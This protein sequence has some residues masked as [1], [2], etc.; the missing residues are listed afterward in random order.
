MP[1]EVTNVFIAGVG[2]QGILLASEILSEVA[3]SRGLDVKKSEVHGMAQRGGA[4]QSHLRISSDPIASDLIPKGACDVL[5]S[6]EPL[7]ALRYLPWL[8]HDST[9]VTSINPH[10]NI[11][12]YPDN[13]SLWAEFGKVEHVI[14]IDAASIAK[15][16]GSPL[17]ANMV[18]LGAASVFIDLM[19][20]DLEKWVAYLWKTKGQ[21]VVDIN[22]KAFH[23]GRRMAEFLRNA[24]RAGAGL[25]GLRALTANVPV[26]AADP[27]SAGEWVELLKANPA[28]KWPD[29]ISEKVAAS[30][31]A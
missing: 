5:L 9:I 18:M 20:E 6:V 13:E 25:D 30:A 15:H 23:A 19:V 22:T 14:P 31:T 16:S 26:D 7:E 11:P 3:L 29:A 10:V 24:S 27:A 4:V 2:G 8:N 17:A 12:N 21:K 28:D 1:S